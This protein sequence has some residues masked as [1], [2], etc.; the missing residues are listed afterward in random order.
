MILGHGFIEREG[1]IKYCV[2][3]FNENIQEPSACGKSFYSSKPK[4]MFSFYILLGCIEVGN[5]KII[6]CPSLLVLHQ[7]TGIL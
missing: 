3:L 4:R 2:K 5:Q 7:G 1:M 6:T